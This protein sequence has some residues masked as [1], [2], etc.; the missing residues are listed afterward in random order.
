MEQK[1][2]IDG[3]YFWYNNQPKLQAQVSKF[4]IPSRVGMFLRRLSCLVMLVYVI[5]R[6]IYNKSNLNDVK[7]LTT[8]GIYLTLGSF[9]LGS[10]G[11][12]IKL[13][14]NSQKCYIIIFQ[15]AIVMEINITLS[16]WTALYPHKDF[17]SVKVKFCEGRP[18]SCFQLFADHWLPLALLVI[19]FILS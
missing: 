17:D 12:N 11:T 1:N 14:F 13:P 5:L 3:G 2:Y 9:V 8:W 6:F 19:D 16:F 15:L 4:I 18:F 10:F 7:Y